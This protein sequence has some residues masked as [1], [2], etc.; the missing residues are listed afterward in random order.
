MSHPRSAFG[1]PPQGG[2]ASGPAEPDPRRPLD[3]SR[4]AALARETHSE[5]QAARPIIWSIAGTD[6]GGGAGLAADQRMADAFGVHLCG[7]VAAITAQNSM[8]VTH[9]APVGVTRLDAQLAALDEDMPPRVVK[10]GLLGTAEQIERVAHWIDRLRARADVT[11]VVD[12]VLSS[13]TGAAFAT[14]DALR[15]YRELLV[16]RATVL[17]PNRR[18]AERLLG[19]RAAV[20]AMARQLK[21]MGAGTVCIKGGDHIEVSGLSLDWLDSPHANGWLATERIATPHT[22]GTGCS[23][24]TAVA[25]AMA[26]GFVS[27]D[28]VVLAK[29]ATTH[30]IA[31][32]DAA[33][34][35][36]GPVRA[37]EGFASDASRLPRMSWSES[38]DFERGALPS[39]RRKLGLYAIVDSVERVKA[40]LDAGVRSVQLRIKT[41]THADGAWH[42]SLCEQIRQSVAACEEAGAE[43]F[44][45]DHWQLA[46]ELGAPGVHLGQ[47]DLAALGD[48]ERARLRDGGVSLGI[49]SHS[50]WE[51]CRAASMAPRYIACGPVWPTLT[52]AMPWRPQ[53]LHNLQWWCDMSPSPVVAIG[54]VLRAEQVRDAARCGADGVCIVRGLGDEPGATVPAFAAALDEGE[55]MPRIAR[56]GDLPHPSL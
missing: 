18:E 25:S 42:A 22:H 48:P 32:G 19:T 29:M 6:S 31:H 21:A 56:H 44:V 30:A 51:L 11:L 34:H 37:R 28:A 43:L 53:G 20:P 24:A 4:V 52:K 10:T 8:R 23:F 38:P 50:L 55:G 47:E 39:M 40:V 14:A 1:A 49:S 9:I 7:V 27:A 26:L 41:P 13:S 54:G 15:A 12:P 3:G 45:N 5:M 2:A 16:P 17:T 35:G 36:A 46:V 33:G